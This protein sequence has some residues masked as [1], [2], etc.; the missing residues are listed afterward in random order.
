[1]RRWRRAIRH[2]FHKLLS[3]FTNGSRHNCS[4]ALS[5]KTLIFPPLLNNFLSLSSRRVL[6]LLSSLGMARLRA[7]ADG[8]CKVAK[9]RMEMK[10]CLNKREREKGRRIKIAYYSQHLHLFY[11]VGVC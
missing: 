1:M 6:L 9:K 8:S 5:L 3:I 11:I 4:I 7:A 10:I 2:A